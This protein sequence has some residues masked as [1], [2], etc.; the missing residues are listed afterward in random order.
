ME[1]RKRL[2]FEELLTLQ[3]GLFIIKSRTK[4]MKEGI[5]FPHIEELESFVSKLPFNLTSAQ[6]K[7]I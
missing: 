5:K 7:G 3:L 1:A 2:A 6:K 4:E